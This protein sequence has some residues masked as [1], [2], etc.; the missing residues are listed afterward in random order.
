MKRNG[1]ELFGCSQ[2]RGANIDPSGPPQPRLDS[3]RLH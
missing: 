1:P 3:V 2:I